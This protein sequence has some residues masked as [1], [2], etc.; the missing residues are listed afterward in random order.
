MLMEIVDR[1]VAIME[2]L[3]SIPEGVGITEISKKTGIPKSAVYRMLQALSDN[4]WASRVPTS[5][6]YRLGL[7]FAE[8]SARGDY[9]RYLA[10]VAMGHLEKLR[11]T[12]G[13]AVFLICPVY[14][15][16]MCLACIPGTGNM[17]Y[18]V[19]VGRVMPVHASAGALAVCAFLSPKNQE[20]MIGTADYL[21]YT[22]RTMTSPTQLRERLLEVNKNEYAICDEEMEEGIVAVSVPVLDKAGF[23]ICSVAYLGLAPQVRRSF[24]EDLPKLF[25]TAKLISSELR[26]KGTARK[27]TT[28]NST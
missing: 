27:P 18:F 5:R 19:E 22:P 13:R 11:E 10:S 2:A 17:K 6:K 1:I 9:G 12:L 20:A 7:G 16:C 21:A 28:K 15:H 14:D 26:S 24:D 25:A 4:E 3:Y 8:L 23:A